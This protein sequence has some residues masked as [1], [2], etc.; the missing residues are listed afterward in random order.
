MRKKNALKKRT[1]RIGFKENEKS[2]LGPEKRKMQMVGTSKEKKDGQTSGEKTEERNEGVK[3][4]N[5]GW[6]DK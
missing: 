4:T 3:Q 2:V 5:R 6:K 1:V